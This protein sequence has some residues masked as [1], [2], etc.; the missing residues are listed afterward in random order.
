MIQNYILT[1]NFVKEKSQIFG[2]HINLQSQAIYVDKMFFKKSLHI[3]E[4]NASSVQANIL[5]M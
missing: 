5:N 2:K 1:L 4:D 3:L